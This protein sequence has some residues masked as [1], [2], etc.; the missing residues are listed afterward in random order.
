VAT[1]TKQELTDLA[2]Y[3]SAVGDWLREKTEARHHEDMA[4]AVDAAFLIIDD[5]V[6]NNITVNKPGS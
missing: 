2:G 1:Y 4:D 6:D 5:L 3:L